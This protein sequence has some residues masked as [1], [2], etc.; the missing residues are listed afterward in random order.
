MALSDELISLFV[1]TTKDEQEKKSE[2][3]VYG[4]TVEREG[5]MY[6]HID[7]AP[8]EL[9]TPIAT[10][11]NLTAGER[12]TVMIKNHTATVTGNISSPAARMGDIEDQAD[13]ITAMEIAIAKKVDT[14]TL[15]AETARIDTL[16]SENVTIKE[17]LTV[18]EGDI[19]ILQTNI[20]TVNEQLTARDAEIENLKTTKLDASVADITYATIE[21]LQATDADIYNLN[22]TYA[23]FV[24]TTTEKLTA[25]EA[26]IQTLKVNKLDATTADIKYATINNL[27]AESARIDDLEADV[28]DIDTLIFGSA[29]GTSIHTSFANAVIAQ[30]GD[31]QIKS[32]M[33]D[34]VS[35]SKITAGDIIT[36]N[37]RV[38]SEDGSLIISDETMQI[39]DGNRVRVQIG[40]DASN[41]YSINIWDA[42]GNLMFSK[43][44]IT[45]SAIKEAIIRNDMVSD[46]ANIAAHKLDI[47]SLFEEIN[48]SEK[49]IKSSRIYLNDQEQTLDVAFETVTTDIEEIQNGMSS[50]GTQITAIQ[51]QIASKVWQ[52]DID[53]AVS[54]VSG[55]TETLSTQFTTLEQEVDNI[56]ATVASHTST[57]STKADSSTVTEVSNRV[58]SIEA[59][60]EGFESTVSST[61]VTKTELASVEVGGRNLLLNSKA[62]KGSN[63]ISVATFADDTYKDFSIRTYDGTTITGNYTDIITFKNI[64]AETLGSTYTFSF[65]AK[66]TGNRTL[67]TYFYGA[68]EY[69]RIARV[70]QSSGVTG[71]AADGASYWT[72]TDD[73]QRYWV[74]WTLREEGNIDIERYVMFRLYPGGTVDICG[75]KLEKGDKA[76]DWT[77]APEDVDGDI[78]I[79]QAAAEAA[80][81]TANQNA[82][83]MANIVTAFN[84][85][86]SNLQTQID[87]SITTWFYSGVP[88]NNTEPAVHWSTDALK[89]VHIGDLYYDDDTGYGY[90]Y[91]VTNG[92]YNWQ[93]I[94]DT[95]VTKAL[96]DA[97]AA[98][99][100]ADQKRRVFYTQPT[101]PYDKGDLW[102][103]GS[104]GDI[105]RCQTA[106][107]T[108][109][110][111]SA[112]DW[113][114]ASKYT[115]DTVANSAVQQ[116]A[117]AQQVANAAQEDINNL[118]IGGR[119]LLRNSKGD[120]STDLSYP[121]PV[122]SDDVKG[123]C[124]ERT[125]VT[126]GNENYIG[127]SRTDIVDPSTEYTF[128]VDLWCNEYLKS[129]D[130]FWLSDTYE[131]VKT[132]AGYVNVISYANR[133]IT[134]NAWT[135][136]S[137][138]FVTNASDRTGYI[139]IDNNGTTE[140]GTESILRAANLKLEKGNRA[141]EWT[142]APEDV[143]DRITTAETK[144]IQNEDSITTLA[145]RTTTVENKFTGYSTTEQM[146][147]A[148]EQSA[149]SITSS[150]SET[151]TTKTE[152]K[153]LEVGGRNLVAGTDEVREY[154][155][156]ITS[157][158]NGTYL[159][160]WSGKTIDV[161]G[162][163]SYIVSFDAKADVA[164]SMTCYFYSPNTTT[165]ALSST[166]HSSKSQDGSVQVSLTTE[167][168]RYWVKW[169]Q[170]PADAKKNIIVGRN[171]T[172]NDIY[173]RAVKF[174]A[175][176]TPTDWTPA[177]EDMATSDELD[178]LQST[179]E[180]IETQLTTAESLI[181]QLSDCISMLVTDGNGESLMTQ[182]S[183]G[184]TFSTSQIQD[185]VDTTSEKLDVLTN[186]VGD[187]D[188]AVNVL[189]QA[190]ND[191][192]VIS[193][194][195]KITVYDGEPCIE[196]GETDSDFKLL[197]T[198]TR[199][200][201]MEGTG[202]PAYINNQSLFINKAVIEEELQQGE[203][204]WKARSNGNLGLIWKGVTS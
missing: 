201:F 134:P 56:S 167:W 155:G 73:W 200:M 202:V 204:V 100:T 187:I 74:T 22:A 123:Y 55:A 128:S 65:Y 174:E 15:N 33:I 186:D 48:G 136:V 70:V 25:T 199:I 12:V 64:Y 129:F 196:L 30:L 10:T 126:T 127:S 108:A 115:D 176:N 140:A 53:T 192:G 50:Q 111:Y 131:E 156:N 97:H 31:A 4:K 145:D 103:Q 43:G 32:A 137:W 45:D 118:K 63:I 81:A 159:D 117:N 185:I 6:V 61:Y 99:D 62:F 85:D 78:A 148:I 106:K 23:D 39:S 36:N 75:C 83:D 94:T 92:S 172:E 143:E 165:S 17:H 71:T 9:L 110:S 114:A 96:A 82:T 79:A 144:I 49:T 40:K 24:E 162:D 147:S 51:G 66:G 116:A 179:T 184:W 139:R 87:G 175:G 113:V 38:M 141:T 193:E 5:E 180:I 198:N 69:V 26:D 59:S 11:T 93:R 181:A 42:D 102:V 160:V 120:N 190:V 170:T 41:D 72:L 154:V 13:A 197:I 157:G 171:F 151:Y 135:R 150:V 37:V 44:G 98:Q 2:S 1:K 54:E 109:Q 86:I 77:P 14:E 178:S 47:N 104:D 142:P 27:K 18:A 132:A 34:S 188:S 16:V 107:T 138:T 88:T 68:T 163:T 29:T 8:N 3:I 203:F 124:L 20:L 173:I 46:T 112:S 57:L 152:F 84:T 89:N 133:K 164:Q 169:T 189:Q 119:N 60:L 105:L 52:Q 28:A 183:N 7:G 158:G 101:V 153:S 21:D 76:T 58:T 121:A 122:V 177:P 19:D 125:N 90:R 161:A 149:Q 67:C 91:R 166:G 130:L 194:Y 80:Q 182:T 191:L 35:A 95:D 195:V 168:A 146:N